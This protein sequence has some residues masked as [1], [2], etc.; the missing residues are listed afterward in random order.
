MPGALPEFESSFSQR[1]LLLR[2]RVIYKDGARLAP[3]WRGTEPLP[4]AAGATTLRL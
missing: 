3:H 2:W 1:D 4:L